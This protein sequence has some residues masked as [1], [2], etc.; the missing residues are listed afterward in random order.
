[1]F[2]EL[3]DLTLA[4]QQAENGNNIDIVLGP[5]ELGKYKT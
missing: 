4:T 1:M 2:T 5:L 3:Y